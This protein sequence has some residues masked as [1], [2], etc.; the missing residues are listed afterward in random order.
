MAEAALRYAGCSYRI[1]LLAAHQCQN[2]RDRAAL[3]QRGI[4]ALSTAA[5]AE[6]ACGSPNPKPGQGGAGSKL[7]WA[8]AAGMPAAHGAGD[9]GVAGAQVQHPAAPP[10][11]LD[12]ASLRAEQVIAPSPALTH[13]SRQARQVSW[14]AGQQ[15]TR[16]PLQSGHR[17]HAWPQAVMETLVPGC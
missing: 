7:T 4:L 2:W 15:A 6:G 1:W 10:G 9:A 8:A 16:L 11:V 17:L 3:L 13:A 12:A 14:D 5:P